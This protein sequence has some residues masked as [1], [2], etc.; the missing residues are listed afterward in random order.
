[1]E[2]HGGSSAGHGRSRG[3]SRGRSLG[4]G[5]DGELGRS[6]EAAR[7]RLTAALARRL[8]ATAS[9]GEECERERSSGRERGGSSAAFIKRERERRGC[10]REGEN[11]RPS[12]PL[13]AVVSPLMERERG[14]R[15][16]ER[17]NGGGF[18]L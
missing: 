17:R 14:E 3:L 18:R 10:H 5:A 11:N 8:G 1:M 13:M 4:T 16:R 2:I 9:K 6:G 7:A 12:T 15:E